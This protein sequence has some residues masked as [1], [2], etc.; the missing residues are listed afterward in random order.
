MGAKQWLYWEMLEHDTTCRAQMELFVPSLSA[1]LC[2]AAVGVAGPVFFHPARMAAPALPFCRTP[3]LLRSAACLVVELELVRLA[4]VG[5]Y[6][7]AVAA[8]AVAGW[9]SRQGPLERLG[10]QTLNPLLPGAQT[11]ASIFVRAVPQ[12]L[13]SPVPGM[14]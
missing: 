7:G 9:P 2:T 3:Q 11:E 12:D 14:G 10:D 8:Q 4:E 5:L 6:L 13:Q 1:R